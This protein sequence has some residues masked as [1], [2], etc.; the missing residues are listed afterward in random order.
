M[1][2]ICIIM[3]T[4]Q[5]ERYLASQIDSIIKNTNQNIELHIFDDGST[6]NTFAIAEKYAGR[7]PEKIYATRNAKNRG[8]V[9]N[10]LEATISLEADYYMYC[11]QDD[12]W[13]PEKIQKTM[14]Y[15]KRQEEACTSE[16]P[17]VVVFSDAIVTDADLAETAPSFQKIGRASWR[18][19]V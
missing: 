13:L 6:D 3:A 9:H 7:F 16:N 1:K 15:M 10:F 12:V 14:D 2:Q 17:P 8:V 4:Y 5:G 18:E 11:D 19:R